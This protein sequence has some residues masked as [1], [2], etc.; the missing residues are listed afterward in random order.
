MTHDNG[1]L[2][3]VWGRAEVFNGTNWNQICDDDFTLSNARVI[4]RSLG[5]PLRDVDIL[6]AQKAK[7]YYRYDLVKGPNY[8]SNAVNCSGTESSLAYCPYKSRTYCSHTEDVY[9]HCAY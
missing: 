1:T 7:Y 8:Y 9:V 2:Y 4:C 6:N 5:L 3:S